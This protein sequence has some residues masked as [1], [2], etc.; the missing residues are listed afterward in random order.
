MTV[1]LVK[2]RSSSMLAY[3]KTAIHSKSMNFISVCK[4]SFSLRRNSHHGCNAPCLFRIGDDL[5]WRILKLLSL[6]DVIHLRVTCKKM[7]Q[8]T[9]SLGKHMFY[10]FV[11]SNHIQITE[12]YS[13]LLSVQ[14]P[15]SPFQNV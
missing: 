5:L 10:N 6:P 7:N 14:Y 9:Q 1:V 15:K 12:H 2:P 13:S 3:K 11:N 4:P 8:I